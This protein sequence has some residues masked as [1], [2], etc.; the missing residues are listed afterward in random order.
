MKTQKP[1]ATHYRQGDVLIERIGPMPAKL[2]K[3]PREGGLIILAH[4]TATGHSHAIASQNATLSRVEG[5]SS[6]MF[7]SVR[8]A[9]AAL[10]HEEHRT[11]NL[12]PGNYRVSR[13]REYSPEAIRNVAD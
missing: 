10:K 7:L 8:T 11:I 5:D 2:K 3:V 13:Q 1:K 6:G 9:K 4:G 12:P